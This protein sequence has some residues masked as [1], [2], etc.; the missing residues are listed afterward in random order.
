[1]IKCI[2][3]A[4]IS[5]ADIFVLCKF[6]TDEQLPVLQRPKISRNTQLT[7]DSLLSGTKQRIEDRYA[8]LK[9]IGFKVYTDSFIQ[10][11]PPMKQLWY[12]FWNDEGLSLAKLGVKRS[13]MEGRIKFKWSY[14]GG[15]TAA[16]ITLGRS[17]IQKH[18]L[19]DDFFNHYSNA[20]EEKEKKNCATKK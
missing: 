9:K 15:K 5:F 7:I 12:K 6:Q 10:S 13:E 3:G 17:V 16:C 20:S 14:E 11:Q 2:W 4:S 1:L 19:T 18:K 8:H